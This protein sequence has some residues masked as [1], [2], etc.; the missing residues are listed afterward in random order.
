M[1]LRRGIWAP[2]IFPTIS[3][4]RGLGAQASKS[5]ASSIQH[6]HKDLQCHLAL[7]A[8]GL[9]AKDNG[10]GLTFR[11]GVGLPV[12]IFTLIGKNCSMG[13]DNSRTVLALPEDDIF[14]AFRQLAAG[15]QGP[16][17]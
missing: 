5:W 3:S 9:V 11:D 15:W 13:F 4:I 8:L 12:E 6:L 1:D 17:C 2:L 14:R 7:G 16:A 10:N